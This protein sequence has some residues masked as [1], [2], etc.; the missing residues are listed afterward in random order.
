MATTYS[1][2]LSC[3]SFVAERANGFPRILD[4]IKW[5]ESHSEPVDCCDIYNASGKRVAQYRRPE[6]G[7]YPAECGVWVNAKIA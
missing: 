5:A 7:S 3:D 6:P 2:V 1:A 4:C